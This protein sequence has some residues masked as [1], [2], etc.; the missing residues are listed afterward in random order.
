MKAFPEYVHGQKCGTHGAGDGLCLEHLGPSGLLEAWFVL[1]L[2]KEGLI[3]TLVGSNATS[4]KLSLS[5]GTM[6]VTCHG[7]IESEIVGVV[8]NGHDVDARNAPGHFAQVVCAWCN[9][10]LCDCTVLN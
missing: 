4:S 6:I 10:F 1:L 2:R 5:V 3:I 9:D 8:L 7:P